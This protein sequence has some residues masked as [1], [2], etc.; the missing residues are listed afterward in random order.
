MALTKRVQVLMDPDDYRKLGEMARRRKLSVGELLRSAATEKHLAR[1]THM[2]A[3]VD[4]MAAL[5]LDADE[6]PELRKEILEGDR[7]TLLREALHALIRARRKMDLTELA[8][9]IR[10]ADGFDPKE[11]WGNRNGPG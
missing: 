11:S 5:V 2:H 6:W 9:K 8:G 10:F 1:G 4:E 3:L 7:R